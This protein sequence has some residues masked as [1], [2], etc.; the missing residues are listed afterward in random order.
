MP[1]YFDNIDL[2]VNETGLICDSISLSSS[3]QV[4]EAYQ[5]GRVGNASFSINGPVTK[6]LS[7]SFF[8]NP[9]NDPIFEI[10]ENYKNNLFREDFHGELIQL[11]NL[12]GEFFLDSLSF[13]ITPNEPIKCSAAFS[14]YGELSGEIVDIASKNQID[15]SIAHAWATKVNKGTRNNT[16]LNLSYSVSFDWSPIYILGQKEPVN[17][18]CN[19]MMED[20]DFSILEYTGIEYSGGNFLSEL[21][22]NDYL[23]IY[24]F[25]IYCQSGDQHQAHYTRRFSIS[26]PLIQSSSLNCPIDDFSITN[27]KIKQFF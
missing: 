21:I 25:D 12:S 14:C 1:V 20:I 9:R 18:H 19:K 11:T 24:D 26:D 7:A 10:V 13:E 2:R 23:E 16:I 15:Y 22:D 27:I 17:I 3:N 6:E 5:I 4:S 8:L